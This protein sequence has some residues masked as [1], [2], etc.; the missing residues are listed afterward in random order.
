[1]ALPRKL[2]SPDAAEKLSNLIIPEVDQ[3][4]TE[5]QELRAPAELGETAARRAKTPTSPKLE[6]GVATE[7]SQAA[8]PT[9]PLAHDIEQ[10]LGQDL[11]PIFYNMDKVLQ[12]QFQQEEAKTVLKIKQLLDSGHAQAKKIFKLIF[13]W[14]KMIPGVSTF[15]LKQEA[16]IKT[17]RILRLKDK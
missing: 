11:G 6:P 17:D 10:I 3:P 15:F 2:A 1:M 14:L 13:D 16:K 7:A 8:A 9:D 4:A 5:R 12:Q